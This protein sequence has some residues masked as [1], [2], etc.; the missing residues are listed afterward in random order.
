MHMP[1]HTRMTAP[2]RAS[3][4]VGSDLTTLGLNLAS[5]DI[6]YNTFLSPW[7]EVCPPPLWTSYSPSSLII[8]II[9]II[10]II[11][12]IVVVV[13]TIVILI[14]VINLLFPCAHT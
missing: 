11:I 9:A 12:I 1:L 10:A 14:L 3:L 13:V 8:N 4:A 6:L 5:P 7:A 2:D